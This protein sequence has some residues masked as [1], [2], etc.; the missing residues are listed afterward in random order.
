MEILLKC[1]DDLDDLVAVLRLQFR[2][3]F[4]TRMLLICFLAALAAVLV[5]G[6]P[7]LLAAP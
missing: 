5:L 7:N 4:T 3:L 1:L 6:P 2:S